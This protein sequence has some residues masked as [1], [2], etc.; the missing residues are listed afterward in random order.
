MFAGSGS[1]GGRTAAMY[2]SIVSCKLNDINPFAYLDYV[3]VHVVDRSI[4]S[5][6]ELLPSRVTGKLRREAI[7]DPSTTASAI[8]LLC[9]ALRFL[10]I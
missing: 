3:L 1:G 2:S 7:S 8:G 5:I 4:N 6:D 10:H 9:P